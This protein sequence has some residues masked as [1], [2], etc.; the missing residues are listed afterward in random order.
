MFCPVCRSEY[1]E[2]VSRC[3]DCL[4]HLVDELPHGKAAP[5][6]EGSAGEPVEVYRCHGEPEAELVRSMLEANGIPTMLNGDYVGSGFYH[7]TV[8]P[9]SE[10]GIVVGRADAGPRYLI[11]SGLRGDLAIEGSATK[12]GEMGTTRE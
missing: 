12:Q 7:P 6:W 5:E 8:G 3:A 1:V 11:A 10:I 4:V 2:G 9:L